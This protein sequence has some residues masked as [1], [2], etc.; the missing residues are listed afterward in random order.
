MQQ[1]RMQNKRRNENYGQ[2]VKEI[3]YFRIGTLQ[4]VY[5]ILSHYHYYDKIVKN[6]SNIY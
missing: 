4:G 6:S 5:N 2:Q 1:K 3:N